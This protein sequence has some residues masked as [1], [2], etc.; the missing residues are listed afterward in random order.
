M[1]FRSGEYIGRGYQVEKGAE[2]EVM[3]VMRAKRVPTAEVGPGEMP[4]KVGFEPLPD[5]YK[6]HGTKLVVA[7]ASGGVAGKRNQTLPYVE[8]FE[9][10]KKEWGAVTT[11]GASVQLFGELS[12]DDIFVRKEGSKKL[13]FVRIAKGRNVRDGDGTYAEFYLA[14][15]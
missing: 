11:K 14:A 4:V 13:Y 6:L 2:T 3:L 12:D 8:A 9:P 1:L 15:W 5:E 7:L 10:K